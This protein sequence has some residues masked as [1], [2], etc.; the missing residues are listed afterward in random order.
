M[1]KILIGMLMAGVVVSSS[2]VVAKAD[3]NA[4]ANKDK[5]VSVGDMSTQ[6]SLV[7]Y[8]NGDNNL[9]SITS[10]KATE[11]DKP[12]AAGNGDLLR[13]QSTE[14]DTKYGN[15]QIE[16]DAN[17]F[18]VT[19]LSNSKAPILKVGVINRLYEVNSQVDIKGIATPTLYN[20]SGEKIKGEVILPT[21][22]TSTPGYGE[23]YIEGTDGN[24]DITIAPFIYNVVQF[25]D[26]INVPKGF[27]V[28]KLS[29][30]DILSAGGDNLR[31]YVSHYKTGDTKVIVGV[32]RGVASIRKEIP[33]T[34]GQVAKTD[35]TKTVVK[36]Q[37]AQT[38]ASSI[39][40]KQADYKVPLL[41]QIVISPFTY[42]IIGAILI[43][44]IWFFCF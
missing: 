10:S 31:A 34:F 29:V 17:G 42:I 27:D 14:I 24:G 23:T 3:T 33:I 2:A 21:I 28:N 41:I 25:K 22:N 12:E 9:A 40:K 11:F 20:A 1:K 39:N 15:M 38:K 19:N 6:K 35:S 13:M 4:T 8:K 18:T 37:E 26:S 7:Q 5:V 43:A 30:N 16:R 32:S 36:T 44:L